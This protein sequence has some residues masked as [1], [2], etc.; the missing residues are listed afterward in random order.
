M[1]LLMVPCSTRGRPR[2]SLPKTSSQSWNGLSRCFKSSRSQAQYGAA[3]SVDCR[4][5]V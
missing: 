2:W 3:D 4:S 5:N 1:S